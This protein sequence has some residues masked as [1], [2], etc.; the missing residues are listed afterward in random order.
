MAEQRLHQRARAPSSRDHA[1]RRWRGEA[2]DMR[3]SKIGIRWMCVTGLVAAAAGAIAPSPRLEAHGTE[4]RFVELLQWKKEHISKVYGVGTAALGVQGSRALLTE[5][6]L[7][8][9]VIDNKACVIGS[10]IAFDVDNNY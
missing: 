5:R 1:R 6:S 8:T 7:Q 4:A 10:I 9:K 2:L 3:T